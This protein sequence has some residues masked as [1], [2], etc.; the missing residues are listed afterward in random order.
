[1][2]ALM[3]PTTALPGPHER[4]ESSAGGGGGRVRRQLLWGIMNQIKGC[5]LRGHGRVLAARRCR[6]ADCKPVGIVRTSGVLVTAA[7]H[8][9]LVPRQKEIP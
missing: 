8:L 2:P 1:M 9:L 7:R 4:A 6:S 5:G 3:R